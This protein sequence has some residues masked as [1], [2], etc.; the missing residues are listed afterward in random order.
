MFLAS[1]HPSA[2]TR[3]AERGYDLSVVQSAGTMLSKLLRAAL[4]QVFLFNNIRV[5]DSI[6][7]HELGFQDGASGTKDMDHPDGRSLRHGC[8]DLPGSSELL[9]HLELHA[10][11]LHVLKP[12]RAQINRSIPPWGILESRHRLQ[13]P[14]PYLF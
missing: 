3:A 6:R 7:E 4:E 12:R 2:L 10:A 14:K 13:L 9:G 1:L 11:W 8:Q 5:A